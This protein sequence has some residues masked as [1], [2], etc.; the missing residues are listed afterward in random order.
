MS[1]IDWVCWPCHDRRDNQ[2]DPLKKKDRFK[3]KMKATCE[4]CHKE[5]ATGTR[6]VSY[7]ESP[8]HVAGTYRVCENCGGPK[9]GENPNYGSDETI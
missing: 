8:I 7:E 4:L 3:N 6:W 5:E 2:G 9:K 1:N